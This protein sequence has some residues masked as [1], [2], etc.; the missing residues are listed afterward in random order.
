MKQA[1]RFLRLDIV[2]VKPYLTWKNLAIVLGVP[3][4]LMYFLDDAGLMV[5]FVL[6]SVG[7]MFV[8]YPFSVGEQNGI[9]ALYATL[10]I[11][12]K[13]AVLG[14]YLFTFS[15]DILVCLLTV[16]GMALAAA[17]KGV[18]PDRAAAGLLVCT[19]FA[20]FTLAQ[21]VQLPLY[22]RLGY[23][24]AKVLSVLP[25]LMVPVLVLGY[26]ALGERTR[27]FFAGV[28]AWVAA[29]T[30]LSIVAAAVLWLAAMF[31][32]YDISCAGYRKREF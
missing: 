18:A 29:N 25:F 27:G 10:S 19:G 2:T 32:S 15:V 7:L 5:L 21:A 4:F 16:A 22:F 14:R 12:R 26:G 6:M 23:A 9:D 30:A 1:L 31:V 20:F 8:S 13:T 24:K 3:A 17:A 28:G 11:Q